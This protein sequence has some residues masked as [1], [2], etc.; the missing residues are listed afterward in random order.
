MGAARIVEPSD[1]RALLAEPP[2]LKL[3]PEGRFTESCCT[4]GGLMGPVA[5]FTELIDLAAS[6]FGGAV[7]WA[8]DDFFAE[9][10][11]LL[12]PSEAIFVADKYTDRGKWM[13]GWET[14]RKRGYAASS[15]AYPDH[16]A[17]ILRLGLPGIVRGVVVDTAHFKGNYPEACAIEGASVDGHPDVATLLSSDVRWTELLPRAALAGDAKN[18][19]AVDVPARFTHLRLRIYPDGGVA[20]LRVHGEVMLGARWMGRSDRPQLVDLAAAEH[21]GLVVACNDMFFGSRHNLIMPG[22]AVNMGDGWETKRSRRSGPDWVVVRLAAEGTIERAIVDT[23]HFQGNAPDTCALDVASAETDP[24]GGD[25]A[26]FRPL[27][28]RTSLQPHAA[29]VF[30]DALLAAGDATHVRLR[31]WPDGGVSRLRLF[32]VVSEAGR[33]RAGLRHLRAMPEAELEAALRACCGSSAWVRAMAT[34]RADRPAAFASLA[35]LKEAASERWRALAAAD[36]EE[37]FKAHPRIGEG[38]ADKAESALARRWS[39]K[40]QSKVDGAGQAVRDELRRANKAY[41]ERFNRIYIVCATGKSAEE[42]LTIAKERM[43]GDP[44][45][46]LRR[47]AEEQRKITELRLEKLVR[48]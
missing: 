32:G 22:R 48:G 24:D 39:T 35:A 25:D 27:L 31:I 6:R 17:C 8:T 44:D 1:P 18:R 14:R 34:L 36:W 26:A 42:M 38:K 40:E 12:A 15:R 7:L 47:A 3:S 9:K 13:D 20:R 4:L 29:H 21:G 43:N 19:F 5:D 37:A 28:E 10:E 2:A 41:E 46:E 30:E 11:N 16:D 33:E 23:L 45:V